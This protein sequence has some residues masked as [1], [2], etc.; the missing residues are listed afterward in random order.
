[1]EDLQK[2]IIPPPPP[3]YQPPESLNNSF[4]TQ[5]GDTLNGSGEVSK[6][7]PIDSSTLAP[8]ENGGEG[9]W[10]SL[11]RQ[12]AAKWTGDTTV[13]PKIDSTDVL[14]K[15]AP[16]TATNIA[17][18]IITPT[19]AAN[20]ELSQINSN[21]NFDPNIGIPI[22]TNNNYYQQYQPQQHQQQQ[23]Y[24]TDGVYN[25]YLP[26]FDAYGS[27]GY[28]NGS[29]YPYDTSQQQQHQHQQF[30]QH[31][32]EMS[33]PY[34]QQQQQLQEQ[35]KSRA[36]SSSTKRGRAGTKSTNGA[37]NTTTTGVTTTGIAGGGSVT[38]SSKLSGQLSTIQ[39]RERAQ[40][41]A[42]ALA[43][44]NEMIMRAVATGTVSGDS[45]EHF[46]QAI[47]ADQVG[48]AD[49]VAA[50]YNFTD[51]FPSQPPQLF[52]SSNA[53]SS[54]NTRTLNLFSSISGNTNHSENQSWS[55][56]SGVGVGMVHG[57][58]GDYMDE[59]GRLYYYPPPEDENSLLMFGS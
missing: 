18:P 41:D 32:Q 59:E 42:E 47:S 12:A 46:L 11:L 29:Y 50:S 52:M 5:Y 21:Q 53:A 3:K 20:V 30:L 40:A 49:D 43:A 13:V 58:N 15:N 2:G 55:N 7:G 56:T 31:Q 38:T 35:P 36:A 57:A 25:A 17:L 1:M 33:Y 10:N 8:V 28:T 19:S 9:S 34:H 51:L 4:P 24:S 6:L 45:Y 48:T 54:D 39:Q 14:P 37:I 27:G 44:Q 16:P 22:E 26:Q 23:Q